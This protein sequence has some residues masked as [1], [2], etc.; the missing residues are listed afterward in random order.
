MGNAAFTQRN[1]AR[2]LSNDPAH[3]NLSWRNFSRENLEAS[4][5]RDAVHQLLG[6]AAIAQD[7]TI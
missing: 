1:T 3:N 6:L 2:E 5:R 7:V 4:R